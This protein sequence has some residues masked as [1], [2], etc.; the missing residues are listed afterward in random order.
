MAAIFADDIYRCIFV[1]KKNCI[2]IK[3][4]LTI[5]LGS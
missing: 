2:L 1:Y 3:I 5:V 4:S